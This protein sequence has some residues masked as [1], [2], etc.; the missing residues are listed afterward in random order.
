MYKKPFRWVAWATL[1]IPFS[2]WAQ[3]MDHSSHGM[4]APDTSEVAVVELAPKGGDASSS[5]DEISVETEVAELASGRGGCKHRGGGKKGHEG[6]GG[7]KGGGHGGSHGGMQRKHKEM[8]A[9]MDLIE[10]RLAKIEVMLER[11]LQ[12]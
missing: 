5:N 10:A 9:R 1:L 7:G 8:V 12:R 4:G 6:H 2:V 3:E 11:L